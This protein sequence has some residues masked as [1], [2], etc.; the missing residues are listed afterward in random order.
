MLPIIS[1]ASKGLARYKQYNG[2]RSAGRYEYVPCK[3]C[4]IICKLDEY[5]YIVRNEREIRSKCIMQSKLGIRPAAIRSDHVAKHYD[6]SGSRYRFLSPLVSLDEGKNTFA[7]F[8]SHFPQCRI[9]CCFFLTERSWCITQVHGKQHLSIGLHPANSIP[10]RRERLKRN[11]R[12]WFVF[13][14]TD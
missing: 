14:R 10:Y 12:P 1:D 8:P 2:S 4:Q 11:L 6:T 3:A 5:T 9:C 13:M 7:D